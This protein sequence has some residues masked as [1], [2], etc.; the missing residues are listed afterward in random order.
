MS[1]TQPSKAD[2]S[3][4]KTSKKG[5]RDPSAPSQQAA[6][7]PETK[8]SSSKLASD[9][10][11]KD[12]EKVEEARRAWRALA[13]RYDAQVRETMRSDV[14]IRDFAVFADDPS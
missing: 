2:S 4:S 13:Q 9:R 10:A 1:S 8:T 7:V 12:D 5:K 14:S 3:S 6:N 11:G